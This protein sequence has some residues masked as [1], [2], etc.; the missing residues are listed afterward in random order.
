VAGWSYQWIS[1]LSFSPDSWSAPMDLM[2]LP[3]ETD[4]TTATISQVK[5]L[6][7]LLPDEGEVPLFVFDAG[8]DAA[9]LADGLKDVRADVLVRIAETRVF[10]PDPPERGPGAMG[11]PRRHGARLPLADQSTWTAPDATARL[12]DRRYGAITVS[13]WHKLHPKLHGH[14]RW[15]GEDELPIVRGSVLRVEVEH[16]PKATARGKKTLWLW[17]SG[18]GKPDVER[19]VIAYLRRF[20]IKHGFRFKK[21]TLAWTTPAVCTPQQA[22]RW[23]WLVAAA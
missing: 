6:V 11:R 19:C 7:G 21:G 2:R 9:G 12:S 14:G 8:Y 15:K 18:A 17:W 16:L 10:H 3:L 23:T 4:A 13:A 22:D 5:R 1:Q 20:D